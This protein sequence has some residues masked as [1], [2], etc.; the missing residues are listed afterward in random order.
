MDTY[1]L[2]PHIIVVYENTELKVRLTRFC[3]AQI[4]NGWPNTSCLDLI[5]K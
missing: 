3:D 4:Q 5:A 2:T 1:S